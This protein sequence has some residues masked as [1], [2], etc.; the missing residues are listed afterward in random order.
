MF[1]GMCVM[2]F[3]EPG[4]RL[5]FGPEAALPARPG[6]M[7][8][9]ISEWRAFLDSSIALQGCC[10]CLARGDSCHRPGRTLESQCPSTMPIM[11]LWHFELGQLLVSAGITQ[12]D[13]VIDRREGSRRRLSLSKPRPWV[14]PGGAGLFHELTFPS[15]FDILEVGFKLPQ[16]ACAVWGSCR[17]WVLV[18]GS[19]V[20][21]VCEASR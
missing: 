12:S 13:T 5:A 19:G 8:L 10:E 14:H 4:C 11:Y 1:F 9:S 6:P 17:G 15:V 7:A 16:E 20:P 3:S 2:F 18:L 21:C